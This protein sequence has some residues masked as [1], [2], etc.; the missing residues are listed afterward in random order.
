MNHKPGPM[1]PWPCQR[2]RMT[3]VRFVGPIKRATICRHNQILRQLELPEV[4]HERMVLEWET[5][6]GV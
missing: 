6:A 5:M 4:G 1:L 3:Q 2:C